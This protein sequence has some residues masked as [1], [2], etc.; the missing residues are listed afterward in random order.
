MKMS[1]L[2][3]RNKGS[4]L[5]PFMFKQRLLH[6]SS[7]IHPVITRNHIRR[8]TTASTAYARS[9]DL[10]HK[11]QAI[12]PSPRV[13][14][15]LEH[16]SSNAPQSSLDNSNALE[17]KP[18]SADAYL[19]QDLEQLLNPDPQYDG[20]F[21]FLD[22]EHLKEEI[23]VFRDQDYIYTVLPTLDGLAHDDLA[24]EYQDSLSF[25]L[26][27]VHLDDDSKSKCDVTLEGI[28]CYY[29]RLG[30]LS[31]QDIQTG[32]RWMTNH[33]LLVNITTQPMSLWLAYDYVRFDDDLKPHL[34]SLADP[35]N[36]L[37]FVDRIW[38]Q[39][40][41][42]LL[43]S[44]SNPPSTNDQSLL[45][46]PPKGILG[47]QDPFDL[48]ALSKDIRADWKGRVQSGLDPEKVRE[49]MHTNRFLYGN[50]LR[51]VPSS[52]Y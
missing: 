30:R 20:H 26:K 41:K 34:R 32:S 46:E 4:F 51:A 38:H 9:S 22:S 16:G 12:L 29:V 47:F 3:I 44:E 25:F 48:A 43:D 15:R 33:V 8:P 18:R 14:L 50:T 7:G 52:P 27:F 2:S 39:G 40:K 37:Q 45:R 24:T 5:R 36:G 42:T 49:V 35:P 21:K 1:L 13:H 31:C 19:E 11:H 28:L 17:E 10:I 6:H 23:C